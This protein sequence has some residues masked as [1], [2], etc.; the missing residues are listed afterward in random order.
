MVCLE[1]LPVRAVYGVSPEFVVRLRW[2]ASS[3]W[4]AELRGLSARSGGHS[5]FSGPG[6]F[7]GAHVPVGKALRLPWASNNAAAILEVY[8][9][10]GGDRCT[11]L[12]FLRFEHIP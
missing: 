2:S 6:Q 9:Y 10:L 8:G 12:K 11:P 5:R 1:D 4:K 7:R 3:P